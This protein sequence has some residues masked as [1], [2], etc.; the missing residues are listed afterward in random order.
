MAVAAHALALLLC[1]TLWWYVWRTGPTP[2]RN[3]FL[4][5]VALVAWWSLCATLAAAALDWGDPASAWPLRWERLG[6]VSAALVPLAW[7]TFIDA[8][9]GRGGPH[10]L[11]SALLALVPLLTITL[12]LVEP[13]LGWLLVDQGEGGWSRG[14]WFWLVHVPYGYALLLLGGVIAW[15][16]R[17]GSSATVRRQLRFLLLAAAVPLAGNLLDLGGW[18]PWPGFEFTVVGF[19]I[20]AVALTF[21]IAQQRFLRLPPSAQRAPYAGL[22]EPV[23][24]LD[25]QRRVIDRNAAAARLL[26]SSDDG[27]PPLG[28]LLPSVAAALR[29]LGDAGGTLEVHVPTLPGKRAEVVLTPLRDGA[30]PP[31][32]FV[33]TIRP[34]NAAAGLTA[35]S[36]SRT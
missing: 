29:V 25:A 11:R 13:R 9:V 23:L 2:A 1:L 4:P 26:P 22:D 7:F 34:L 35:A 3:W 33:L 8:F 19:A 5:F 31:Y 28:R 16:G 18:R 30:R 14:P 21:A 15:R 36:P 10:R 27:A 32:G 24:F 20:G 17:S 12:A 6:F